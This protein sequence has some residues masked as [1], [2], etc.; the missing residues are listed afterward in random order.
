LH[1][2]VGSFAGERE[3]LVVEGLEVTANVGNA[4]R[5]RLIGSSAKDCGINILC[6]FVMG[7]QS[8]LLAK[9]FSSEP[10]VGS[11]QSAPVKPLGQE[12]T[13]W[14]S[15][16]LPSLHS[17]SQTAERSNHKGRACNKG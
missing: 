2:G 5:F 6:A 13:L 11:E 15:Q 8:G 4:S 10:S 16:R 7:V 12:H 1:Q 3:S 17:G 9:V 14:G